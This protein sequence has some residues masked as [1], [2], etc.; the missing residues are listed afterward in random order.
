MLVTNGVK[1]RNI[2]SE[3]L[4]EYAAKGYSEVKTPEKPKAPTKARK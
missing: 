1:T 3:K 4:P 2:S